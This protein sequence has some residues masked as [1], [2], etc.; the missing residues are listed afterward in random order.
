MIV[1]APDEQEARGTNEC[2][3]CTGKCETTSPESQAANTRIKKVFE[4]D[5]GCVLGAHA[6]SLQKSKSCL[7]D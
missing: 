3:A 5:V 2:V 6:T 1:V 4:Q 7:H